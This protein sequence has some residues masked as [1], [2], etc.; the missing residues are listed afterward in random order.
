MAGGALSADKVHDMHTKEQFLLSISEK[1]YGKRTSAYAYRCANRGGQG[2]ATM[3]VT[4][5]TGRIVNTLPVKETDHILLLT[6]QGQLLRCGV[7]DIRISGRKT[8]GVRLFRLGLG[9]RIVSIAVFP[10]DSVT[11]DATPALVSGLTTGDIT[12]PLA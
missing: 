9:E 8:Q 11:D 4:E 3:D 10:A 6:D 5:K 2:V 1:G 7:C 12:P